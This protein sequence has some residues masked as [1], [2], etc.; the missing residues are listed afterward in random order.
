M[1]EKYDEAIKHY[2]EIIE[3]DNKSDDIYYNLANSLYMKKDLSTA[4]VY[5]KKAIEANPDKFEYHYNLG[6]AYCINE[7]FD[8]ALESF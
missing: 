3:I 6:N 4:I 5:Y 1:I 8:L 7:E 2:T